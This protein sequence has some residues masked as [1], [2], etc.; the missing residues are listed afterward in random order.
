LV[1]ALGLSVAQELFPDDESPLGKYV[2][3]GTAPFQIVAVM[4]SKGVS[5]RGYDLDYQVWIPY[6]TASSLLFGRRYFEDVNVKVINA[7]LMKPVERSI[8]T[9]LL[10]SHG[11][12]DFNIRN[13]ADLINTANQTQ[14]TFTNLL[15]AVAVISLIVGGIGVMNIMLVSVTERT[16]EIGIR[17][18]VG[19][20]SFDVLLQ[21]LTEAVVVCAIG[22]MIGVALGV[23]GGLATSRAMG[24]LTV[25]SA[26]PCAL[27]FGCA[28]LTGMVFGFLP[29]RK[30][31]R[32]DPVEALARD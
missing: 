20:R 5:S 11:E 27:A 28:F 23:A 14:N 15:G 25:V 9:V 2:M 26:T 10:R 32:L 8:H 18:A 7:S 22:G 16:R 3:I 12:E 29:A 31:A 19:A 4:A 30:A 1:V 21:F 13:M 17:M 6:T 24:W